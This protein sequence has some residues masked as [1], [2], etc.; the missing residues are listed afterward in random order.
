MLLENVQISNVFHFN[1]YRNC[2]VPVP[3]FHLYN[4]ELKVLD[5][6]TYLGM[7]FDKHVNLS[8]LCLML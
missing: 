3:V 4:Q 6:F 8:K 1:G 2:A 5:S 7:L